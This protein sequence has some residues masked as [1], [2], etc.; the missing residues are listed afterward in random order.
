MID[1]N[2]W[3]QAAAWR[4]G[5]AYVEVTAR[6]KIGNFLNSLQ[7]RLKATGAAALR[8]GAS[9]AG[10]GVGALGLLSPAI[11]AA[12]NLE[13][14]MNKFNVVFGSNAETVKQ[15]GDGFADQVGRSKRQ[16]AEFMAESQDLFVPLGFDDASAT[17]LSQTVTSLAVDLASFNNMQDADVLRDFKAA[18]TGS[19]E[20]MKKY[21]VIL[22]QA[23]VN[24]ELLN[25]SIDPKN[26]SETEKVQA[27]LAIITRGTAA[28]QGDATRSAGSWANQ[29]KRVKGIIEDTA[30][31]VGSALLPEIT[32]LLAKFGDAAKLAAQWAADNAPL[33]AT[34]F[35]VAAA[36]AAV[37]T[38]V[39]TA[40]A[41]LIGIG[42]AISAATTLFGAL[43]SAIGLLFTPL[44]LTI[45]AVVGLGAVILTQTEMGA[46]ALQFLSD[47]FD[48]LAV[49]AGQTW[50]GISDAFA[51]G[52]LQLAAE[53]LWA[54]LRLA[55]TTGS[56][57]ISD[58]TANLVASLEK[59]WVNLTASIGNV[60]IVLAG[61]VTGVLD[62]IRNHFASIF[63]DIS[64][65]PGADIILGF[66][67]ADALG[68]LGEAIRPD[69]NKPTTQDIIDEN[70]AD[71]RRRIADID[72]ENAGRGRNG[73][74]AIAA[75][76]AE[77]DALTARANQQRKDAEAKAKEKTETKPEASTPPAIAA[78]VDGLNRSA[79]S[80]TALR[81]DAGLAAVAAVFRGAAG[82]SPEEK[83]AKNTAKIAAATETIAEN[84]KDRPVPATPPA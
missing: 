82:N 84:T 16:I 1:R 62:T 49:V 9:I 46:Q 40:G 79:N 20:V 6:D 37:G 5:K 22:S 26:A 34:A 72:R 61:F 48:A 55:W 70:E 59:M 8:V 28:A 76:R 39:A 11:T 64:N 58:K 78:A 44:G 83:T 65:L 12:S 71:R 7:R 51:T 80:A 32:P 2:L 38:A 52:D 73:A 13:E 19:G 27:R 18:L 17:Q 50:Q 53:I 15:W 75:A 60:F 31:A 67:V 66:G 33:I 69:A 29:M 23:A 35:K 4:A 42:A 25:R 24:Q 45:A 30:A 43:A 56:A 41:L 54:A 14:V 81:S 77:F 57:W 63:T 68:A 3:H 74:A 21:G 47:K 10:I 36:V